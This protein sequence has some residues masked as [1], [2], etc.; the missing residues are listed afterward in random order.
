MIVLRMGQQHDREANSRQLQ[1]ALVELA[2][3]QAQE[4]QVAERMERIEEEGSRPPAR[5][6]RAGSSQ[7]S[8]PT[9]ATA[10][11][12]VH[13]AGEEEAELVDGDASV[14]RDEDYA[15]TADDRGGEDD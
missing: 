1:S 11:M 4:A 8:A 9:Q 7:G 13:D 5:S 14:P 3:L 2:N 10:P 15:G 6:G 12:E